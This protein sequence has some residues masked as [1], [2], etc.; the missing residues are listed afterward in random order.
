MGR[1]TLSKPKVRI[2]ISHHYTTKG[3][4]NEPSSFSEVAIPLSPHLTLKD[5]VSMP[6]LMSLS[7]HHTMDDAKAPQ[8][9]AFYQHGRDSNTWLGRD[10]ILFHGRDA[11]FSENNTTMNLVGSICRGA[12]HMPHLFIGRYGIFRLRQFPHPPILQH[13]AKSY[14]LRYENTTTFVVVLVITNYLLYLPT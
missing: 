7:P 9:H 2:Y 10:R 11:I 6:L 1:T 3:H 12:V 4:G 8:R 5:D 13:P 14:H